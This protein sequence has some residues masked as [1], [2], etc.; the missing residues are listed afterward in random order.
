MN[1]QKILGSIQVATLSFAVS[2]V[3]NASFLH[4]DKIGRLVPT[5][6]YGYIADGGAPVPPY[7]KPPVATN[8]NLVIADGGA[9]VPP[10]PQPP[11]AAN[12][13]LV[14]ADG[15]APVPPYPKPPAAT[16]S[17]IM[18]ADWGHAAS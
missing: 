18:I 11:V 3:G 5:N 9:P 15:G 7:P 14:I 16:N 8:S 10:Y 1:S 4:V 6:Q 17:D 2:L 12:S 13:S